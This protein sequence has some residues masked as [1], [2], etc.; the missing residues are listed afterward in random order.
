MAWYKVKLKSIGNKTSPSF[1]QIEIHVI[2]LNLH[3][4]QYM[5]KL[6]P[7]VLT[8]SLISIPIQYDIPGSL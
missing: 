1:R 5:F 7:S 3:E 2:N 4:P 6:I 8:S